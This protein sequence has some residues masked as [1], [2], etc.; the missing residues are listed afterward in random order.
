VRPL[1][2]QFEH[3]LGQVDGDHGPVEARTHGPQW[4]RPSRLADNPMAWFIQVNG[5]I[6]D[7]RRA[8][9]EI[10]EEAFRQGL[11]PYLP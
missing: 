5:L 10:Q 8:P 9:R 2:P 3:G 11:I 7:A 4:T 6:V 1:R